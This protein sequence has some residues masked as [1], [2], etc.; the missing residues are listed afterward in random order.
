MWVPVHDEEWDGDIP[1][2]EDSHIS[3]PTD[4]EGLNASHEEYGTVVFKGN[5]LP[6]TVGHYEVRYH[7]NMRYNVLALDGPIEI[8]GMFHTSSHMC[9]VRC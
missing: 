7:H 4:E 5:S 3:S 6:W 2:G 8:Y 9:C 1:I